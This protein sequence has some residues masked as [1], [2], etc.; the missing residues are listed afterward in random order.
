[1]QVQLISFVLCKVLIFLTTLSILGWLGRCWCISQLHM[2]E[3]RVHSQ[4]ELPAY[5]RS[6]VSMSGFHTLL[7]STSAVILSRICELW[8]KDLFL[9]LLVV[10]WNL[11]R[12]TLIWILYNVAFLNKWKARTVTVCARLCWVAGGCKSLWYVLSQILTGQIK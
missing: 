4:N 6:Y 8:K 1:M 5:P 9:D 11:K 10:I 12:H 2:G 7:K 3:G